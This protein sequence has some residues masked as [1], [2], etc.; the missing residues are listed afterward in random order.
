MPSLGAPELVII[1][2]IVLILFGGSRVGEIGGAL[3]RGIRE[4][5]DAVRDEETPAE[6]PPKTAVPDEAKASATGEAGTAAR[7]AQTAAGAATGRATNPDRSDPV[8]SREPA[9]SREGRAPSGP[10]ATDEQPR[11]DAP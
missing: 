10:A 6:R 8:E 5:K 9:A 4:F 3:G 11:R 2:A 1:L 7:A